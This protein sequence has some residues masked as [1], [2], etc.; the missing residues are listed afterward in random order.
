MSSSEDAAAGV[1]DDGL[2]NVVEK[3]PKTKKAHA[4][5]ADSRPGIQGPGPGGG[6]SKK[7]TGGVR[8][9]KGS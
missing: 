4:K 7:A 5:K 3:L 8:G 2:W 1:F 9:I 6:R